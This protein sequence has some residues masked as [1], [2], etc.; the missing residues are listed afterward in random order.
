[1]SLITIMTLLQIGRIFYAD[2]GLFYNVTQNSG[3][4]YA[5]TDVI[6]N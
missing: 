1:M 5:T 4:L 2:F 3:S 6:D